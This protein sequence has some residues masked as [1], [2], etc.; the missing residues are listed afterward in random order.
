MTLERNPLV[1]FLIQSSLKNA[2]HP[3]VSKLTFLQE[4]ALKF[5]QNPPTVDVIYFDP[6][7][8]DANANDSPKKE[9]RIY[10]ELLEGDADAEDVLTRALS[11]GVKRIVVKRPRLSRELL[12]K[13]PVRMEGKSTRYD[14]YFP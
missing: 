6:M 2:Q 3:L 13:K 10:R 4:D 11:V 9:M 12:D 5:L 1:V 7:F 8:E 14:V